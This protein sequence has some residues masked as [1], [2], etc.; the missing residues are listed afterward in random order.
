MG[1]AARLIASARVD[2][3]RGAVRVLVVQAE[4]RS[5]HREHALLE[6][7][8]ETVGGG[9]YAGRWLRGEVVRIM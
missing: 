8:R 3:H 1:A 6:G 5:A 4:R 7:L 9:G 2:V